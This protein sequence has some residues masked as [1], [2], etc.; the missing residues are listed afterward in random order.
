MLGV[1]AYTLGFERMLTS[2]A[3]FYPEWFFRS[4][5]DAGL[6]SRSEAKAARSGAAA[7]GAEAEDFVELSA[8]ESAAV[9]GESAAGFFVLAMGRKP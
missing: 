7:R 9:G 1:I 8:S 4:Q 6:W 3:C 2:F 5:R